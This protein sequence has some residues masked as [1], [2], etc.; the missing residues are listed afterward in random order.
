[1]Q[2]SGVQADVSRKRSLGAGNIHFGL[3]IKPFGVE[4]GIYP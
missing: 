1:V 3:G 2:R 4:G